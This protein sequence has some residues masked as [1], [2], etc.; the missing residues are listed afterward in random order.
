MKIFWNSGEAEKIEGLDILGVRRIDQAIEKAWVAGITTISP[1]ARY[2]SLLPWGLTEFYNKHLSTNEKEAFYKSEELELFLRRLEV[3]VLACSILDETEEDPTAGYGALGKDVH[4]GLI[5]ELENKGEINLEPDRGGMIAGA[6]LMPCQGFGILESAEPIRITPRGVELHDVMKSQLG[7]CPLVERLLEGDKISKREVIKNKEH[8]S[9]QGLRSDLAEKERELLLKFFFTAYS[10]S[11][12]PKYD[13]FSATVRWVLKNLAKVDLSAKELISREYSR[14]FRNQSVKPDNVQIAWANYELRRRVHFAFEL[15]FSSLCDTLASKIAGTLQDVVLEWTRT[16]SFPELLTSVLNTERFAWVQPWEE[17]LKAISP[18]SFLAG[19]PSIKS[20][21]ALSQEPRALM[22]L[23]MVSSCW[24]DAI[25]WR[26]KNL[27]IEYP[28]SSLDTAFEILDRANKSK[29]I[30]VLAQIMEQCVVVPHLKTTW[31]KMGQ[32]QKCSLRFYLD[33]DVLRSTGT[34][35][36]AGYSGDRLGNVLS[37]L[38]DLGL[39]EHVKDGCYSI[40][41]KGHLVLRELEKES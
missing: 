14:C 20:A 3:I 33:G 34:S 36:S 2:L 26:Q 6:Y 22:A 30:D 5:K 31:R 32:G 23:V 41:E 15:M 40:N 28:G 4:E 9:L 38:A 1:R 16:S 18:N 25:K 39:I 37:M 12:V 10:P 7:N 19:V 35:V 21:R 17:F 29:V 13:R 8:F 11:S 27:I 24:R